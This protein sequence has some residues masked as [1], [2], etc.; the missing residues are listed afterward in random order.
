M[1]RHLVLLAFLAGCTPDFANPTTVVDLRILGMSAEPPEVVVDIGELPEGE[2]LPAPEVL[3]PRL[4]EAAARLP[5]RFEE[6]TVRPLVVDPR[7]RGRPVRWRV[8]A[9]GNEPPGGSRGRDRGPGGLRDTVSRGACPP[10][11]PVVAEGEA[12]P[13]G[14]PPDVVPPIEFTFQPTRELLARALALDPLGALFGLPIT[15][16]LTVAAGDEEAVGRK[17]ILF[18]P[19]ITA[20]QRPNRNPVLGAVTLRARREAAPEPLDPGGEPPAVAPGGELLVTPELEPLESYVAKAYRRATGRIETEHVERETLRYSFF[21][22]AGT[23]SPARVSTEPSPLRSPP[24]DPLTVTYR[25]PRAD[26]PELPER[27]EVFV[28]VRDERAGQSFL[29]F[30]LRLRR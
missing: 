29:R 3:A 28:I 7:G 17:R 23:F 11:A 2:P 27:V 1:T 25:A 24:T 10:D 18:V 20:D 8:V 4:R 16:E 6:I 22:T 13:A 30:A 19:R 15:L 12:A 21:A 5:E 26:A 9:C 14:D